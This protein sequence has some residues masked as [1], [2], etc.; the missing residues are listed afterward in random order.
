VTWLHCKAMQTA[1]IKPDQQTSLMNVLIP[2][3]YVTNIKPGP[4]FPLHRSR[5][6]EDLGVFPPVY[7]L[8][9][10]SLPLEMIE[11]VV[12]ELLASERN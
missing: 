3:D 2:A 1:A 12:A 6:T 11:R 7:T 4:I 10:D 8:P 9:A 5:P